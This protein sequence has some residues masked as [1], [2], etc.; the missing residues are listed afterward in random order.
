M[1]KSSNLPPVAIVLILSNIFLYAVV[2]EAVMPSKI[3]LL[4]CECLL[5]VLLSKLLLSAVV[6]LAVVPSKTDL[7]VCVCLLEVLLLTLF[8]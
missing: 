3:D 6:K 1:V 4:L 7:F 2:N 8:L 5:V